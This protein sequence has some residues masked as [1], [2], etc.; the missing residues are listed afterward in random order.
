MIPATKSQP[1]IDCM[2][3]PATHGDIVTLDPEEIRDSVFS[4]PI[5]SSSSGVSGASSPQSMAM[6][7]PV[8]PAGADRK[9]S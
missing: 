6:G 4:V 2:F 9:I 3:F 1:S 7:S 8:R 5:P